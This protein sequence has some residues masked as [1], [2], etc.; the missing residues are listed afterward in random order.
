MKKSKLIPGRLEYFVVTHFLQPLTILPWSIVTLA[1]CA[2]RDSKS[3][4]LNTSCDFVLLHKSILINN[5]SSRVFH[6]HSMSLQRSMYMHMESRL[7]TLLFP[8]Y[9]TYTSI[10][11][12]IKNEWPDYGDYIYHYPSLSCVRVIMH[13]PSAFHS[14]SCPQSRHWQSSIISSK[15]T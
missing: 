5:Y 10:K 7:N 6:R 15:C 8:A 1:C 4:S 3:A 12:C 2:M 14:I 11:T 9:L 13:F